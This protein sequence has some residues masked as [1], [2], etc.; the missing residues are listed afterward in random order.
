[1]SHPNVVQCYSWT[2]LTGEASSWGCC[3]WVSDTLAL[4]HLGPCLAPNSVLFLPSQQSQTRAAASP[5]APATPPPGSSR[6]LAGPAAASV[7]SCLPGVAAWS[8][9]DL[10]VR[11]SRAAARAAYGS[12]ACVEAW[13]C[14]S[15]LLLVRGAVGS[16]ASSCLFVAGM[17]CSQAVRS[18]VLA[19]AAK[20]R[21]SDHA[22]S[23]SLRTQAC[24]VAAAAL[25]A[26]TASLSGWGR[27][28][29]QCTKQAQ[30]G[31]VLAPS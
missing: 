23:A 20:G 21:L 11:R 15:M 22:D 26:C 28:Q 5:A 2:V 9:S 27:R 25:P 29:R 7:S 3:P 10:A 4:L 31:W 8:C 19:A 6:S 12:T 14:H 13:T 16:C 30:R 18:N 1:M 17:H 24:C